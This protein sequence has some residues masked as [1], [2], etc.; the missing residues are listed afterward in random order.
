MMRRWIES[1]Y[2]CMQWRSNKEAHL[3][4]KVSE[5][6]LKNYARHPQSGL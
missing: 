4:R 5:V 1:E 6:K 3:P 2:N